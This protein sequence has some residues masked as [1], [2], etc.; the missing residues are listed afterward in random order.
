[1]LHYSDMQYQMDLLSNMT[2]DQIPS[3][4]RTQLD[5][6]IKENCEGE[7]GTRSKTSWGSLT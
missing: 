3:Q 4:E 2:E 6:E 5:G 1:M 7:Q